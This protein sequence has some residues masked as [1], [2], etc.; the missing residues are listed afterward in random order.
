VWILVNDPVGRW[1]IVTE[2]RGGTPSVFVG[3]CAA[4]AVRTGIEAAYPPYAAA[5]QVLEFSDPTQD[6]NHQALANE[7]N[8]IRARVAPPAA[9]DAP[10]L[11]WVTAAEIR[12]LLGPHLSTESISWTDD[13]DRA[14]LETIVQANTPYVAATMADGRF[15]GVVEQCAVAL[16]VAR[17]GLGST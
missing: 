9:G 10:T 3:L 14:A 5:G 13:L 2:T 6:Q 11:G 17:R 12:G 16:Q 7:F 15:R 8:K 4:S 1:I